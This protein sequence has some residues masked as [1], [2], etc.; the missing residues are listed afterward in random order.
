M[1][2]SMEFDE[3]MKGW[4]QNGILLFVDTKLY[5][6]QNKEIDNYFWLLE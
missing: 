4:D 2:G 5:V 3:D 1:M 6:P